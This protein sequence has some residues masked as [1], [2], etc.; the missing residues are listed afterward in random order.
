MPSTV[1]GDDPVHG[2][3]RGFESEP[4]VTRLASPI[5]ARGARAPCPGL[6]PHAEDYGHD[7]C[8]R[9]CVTRVDGV[10]LPRIVLMD[11][12]ADDARGLKPNPYRES[13]VDRARP[14]DDAE[15]DNKAGEHD[16]DN[17]A[18]RELGENLR[19]PHLDAGRF[20]IVGSQLR[21]SLDRK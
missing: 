15:M 7:K 9:E 8:L 4:R 21:P 10:E 6:A 18:P 13:K 3:G 5:S 17:E 19:R 11:D 2:A 20:Q 14:I 1:A 12:G 16:S